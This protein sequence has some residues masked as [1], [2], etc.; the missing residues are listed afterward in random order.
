[1]FEV[2]CALKIY[3]WKAA[4]IFGKLSVR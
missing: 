3:F 4:A 2:I 1:M